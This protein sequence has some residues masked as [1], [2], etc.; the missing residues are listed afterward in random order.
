MTVP[1]PFCRFISSIFQPSAEARLTTDRPI[2]ARSQAIERLGCVKDV[3]RFPWAER[4]DRSAEA[5]S[6][7]AVPSSSA[8]V[9]SPSRRVG[10]GLNPLFSDGVDRVWDVGAFSNV[11]VGCCFA[12]EAL[13]CVCRFAA[14]LLRRPDECDPERVSP[15]EFEWEDAAFSCPAGV[16]SDCRDVVAEEG[17][18]DRSGEACDVWLEATADAARDCVGSDAST[19]TTV[20]RADASALSEDF[21]AVPGALAD[22]GEGRRC[23][24]SGDGAARPAWIFTVDS[25]V[26]AWWGACPFFEVAVVS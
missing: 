9:A 6:D 19:R 10:G 8:A 14:D 20:G 17:A 13:G 12:G 2:V 26:A 21:G 16:P 24:W 4:V 18:A 3:A 5:D 11:K 25:D 22:G 7:E 1:S 15:S 23:V